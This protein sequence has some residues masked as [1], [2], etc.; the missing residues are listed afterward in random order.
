MIGV[1]ATIKTQ[2]GKADDFIAV[3]R[4]LQEQVLANEPTT[5]LYTINRDRKDPNTFIIMERYQD[6]AS[7]DAH[8][9]SE[10]FAAAGAKMGACLAAAPDLN[11]VDEI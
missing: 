11:F 7:L 6:Q 8:M 2:D 5:L 4:E 1:V 3:F 9:A 10:Y